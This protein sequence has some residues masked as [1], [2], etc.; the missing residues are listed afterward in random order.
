MNSTDTNSSKKGENLSFAQIV[1]KDKMKPEVESTSK[2]EV[3]KQ[4][5]IVESEQNT[6]NSS[7]STSNAEVEDGIANSVSMLSLE[8]Q[9]TMNSTT[10][11]D[12]N[13]NEEDSELEFGLDG[14][15]IFVGDLAKGITEEHIEAA[16]ANCGKVAS[17]SIKRDKQTGKNLGYGFV[18]MGS[19][20]EALLAKKTLHQTEI[21]GRK[22]RLG[23]AQKNTSLFVGG[24]DETITLQAFLEAFKEYGPV[25][26]ENCFVRG[27]FGFVKFKYRIH[28]EQA[29][30][31]MNGCHYWNASLKVEWNNT[32]NNQNRACTVHIKLEGDQDISL[33]EGAMNA[34]FEDYPEVIGFSNL[35]E[36]AWSMD[37]KNYKRIYGFVYFVKNRDGER[38]AARAV[39]NLQGS[40]FDGFKIEC[41][42][43][44]P[45]KRYNNGGSS[46]KNN[47]QYRSSSQNLSPAAQ[48]SYPLQVPQMWQPQAAA[49]MPLAA[50]AYQAAVAAAAATSY[51]TTQDVDASADSTTT[52]YS[53]Q[54]VYNPYYANPYTYPQMYSNPYQQPYYGQV[55]MTS[56]IDATQYGVSH[57]GT[58]LYQQMY[59]ASMPQQPMVVP[60]TTVTSPPPPR[61]ESSQKGGRSLPPRFMAQ[62]SNN[63]GSGGYGGGSVPTDA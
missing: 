54:A 21:H 1:G 23:W 60:Q 5:Q 15:N 55:D 16:F 38:A 43:T 25:E 35:K 59:Y 11:V 56:S 30:K 61:S 9:S 12:S 63:S 53:S 52:D 48:Y 62:L 29:R 33:P 10:T 14:C 18:R 47:S 42:L 57:T 32:N 46:R 41:S 6:A 37:G 7:P 44:T 2:I 20:E 31:E 45:P 26:E 17:V 40:C 19:K 28:A 58:D 50:G 51:S 27:K 36:K 8:S 22:V 34:I 24:L 49:Y 13:E 3:A 4:V 39:E